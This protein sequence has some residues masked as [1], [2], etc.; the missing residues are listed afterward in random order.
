MEK[1]WRLTDSFHARNRAKSQTAGPGARSDAGAGAGTLP[2]PTVLG[3]AQ[4]TAA[5]G[6]EPC[7]DVDVAPSIRNVSKRKHSPAA[8][9]L[10]SCLSPGSARRRLL[11]EDGAL[12]IPISH[13]AKDKKAE[14]CSNYN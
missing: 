8:E 1:S 3:P 9:P 10:S 14:F 13:T 7:L 11:S 12:G 4:E 6:E 5:G 2:A